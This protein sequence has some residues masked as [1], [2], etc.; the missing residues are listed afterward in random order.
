MI[1]M[2]TP[3]IAFSIAPIAKFV[4]LA[5]LKRA[6]VCDLSQYNKSERGGS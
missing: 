2:L 4:W 6:L 3:N 5:I 1:S